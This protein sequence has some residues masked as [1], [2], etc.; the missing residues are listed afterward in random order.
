M[1]SQSRPLPRL[2]Q[3]AALLV[4]AGLLAIGGLTACSTTS[5]AG[6]STDA[7][8]SAG[9]A[10]GSGSVAFA[11]DKLS[12]AFVSVQVKE[13]QAAAEK[14]GLPIASV[15]NADGDVAKQIT[16]VNTLL[17]QNISGL[18]IKPADSAAI[19]PAVEKANA[20]G[21][22]VISV[23][24]SVA[25]PGVFMTVQADNYV[26]GQQ[27]CQEMGKLVNG[28]GSVLNL[29]GDLASTGGKQRSDGF[30]DCMSE[31]FPNVQVV[32]KPTNWKADEAAA[33]AQTVVTTS[34]VAGIYL[35]SDTGFGAGVSQV[36][37]NADKWKPVGEDGHIALVS[38][39]G[40]NVALGD[41]RDGYQ[42]ALISQPLNL[43]AQYSVVYMQDAIAKK[44]IAE[45][46]TDHGSTVKK[47]Q[48][49]NLVDLI[50]AP[51][52]TKANAS[53]TTLWG[54]QS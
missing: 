13:V 31:K 14:A 6:G 32:S 2:A 43:F 3:K 37:K 54:N 25:G 16:D 44:T 38:I 1:R 20:Q 10:T 35:A 18:M 4:T 39:D 7:S 5:T 26:M 36:L 12:D 21:V 17:S 50:P 52:V 30:T 49:G 53:D 34:D 48:F 29:Q 45:G 46:A 11:G 24:D 8:G 40:G 28:T 23:S 51:V 9:G 15:T 47:D 41:I 22:P 27:A 19:V 33:A 42:D